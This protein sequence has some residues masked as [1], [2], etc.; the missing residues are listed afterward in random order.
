MGGSSVLNY[1]IYTRGNRKDFDNWAKMGN[2]GTYRYAYRVSPRD[3]YSVISVLIEIVKCL[4]YFKD[5]QG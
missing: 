3:L 2:T 5:S 4:F 1:M